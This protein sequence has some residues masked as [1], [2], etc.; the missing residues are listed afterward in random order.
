M[1]RPWL[2]AL[3]A[4]ALAGGIAGCDPN[5]DEDPDIDA[6]APTP[7]VG[8]ITHPTVA[9]TPVDEF[10]NLN[11]CRGLAGPRG[12]PA[13]IKFKARFGSNVNFTSYQLFAANNAA[14]YDESTT[15]AVCNDTPP[16]DITGFVGN[17]VGPERTDLI[18]GDFVADAVYATSLIVAAVGQA[19]CATGT[20]IFLCM[21]ARR[22][23]TKLGIAKAK[24]FLNVSKPSTPTL[25]SVS[26]GERAL[27]V[28]W[29][30]PSTG[31]HD[32]Y[33]VVT[34][35]SSPLDP[36]WAGTD[37][38][39]TSPRA[40]ATDLRVEGLTNGAVYT[41]HVLAFN[42]ADNPSDP[43]NSTT[44]SPM[45]V[46]DFWEGYEAAGGREQGGCGTGGAGVL[47]LLGLGALLALRRRS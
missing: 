32:S 13:T 40:T 34:R 42:D 26:P 8:V 2:L 14:I 7:D 44:S 20:D 36:E 9:Q 38:V 45:S 18:A 39:R 29:D 21:E 33:A 23:T 3:A 4:A 10:I 12:E 41:V 31:F 19:S 25:T 37:V 17:E 28:D 46:T 35:T 43:S 22:G 6:E 24:V 27:N 1:T 47:A 15:P 16:G 11:E 30:P 5:P